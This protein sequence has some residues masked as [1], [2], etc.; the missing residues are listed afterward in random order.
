M[1]MINILSLPTPPS[2]SLSVDI[3]PSQVYY[4]NEESFHLTIVDPT[5]VTS[6]SFELTCFS[7][8]CDIP[9]IYTDEEMTSSVAVT[10]SDARRKTILTIYFS[11]NK[12]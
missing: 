12:Q 10:S 11:M 5:I 6:L 1:K 7:G 3:T 9:F 2:L 4:G 8:S